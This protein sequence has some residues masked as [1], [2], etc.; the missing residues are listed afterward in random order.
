MGD[1]RTTDEVIRDIVEMG[2][3]PSFCTACYRL[4]R[5]GAD[6]MDMAKPGEI[7][8]HCTPNALS[9]FAE[10]LNDYASPETRAV[11]RA[12]I[13]KMMSEMEEGQVQ[14][15]APMIREV[16]L[17]QEGCVCV[18][19]L[20]TPASCRHYPSRTFSCGGETGGRRSSN[21]PGR[22]DG[23]L[24]ASGGTDPLSDAKAVRRATTR[25]SERS[26]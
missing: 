26:G 4:G 7:K 3:I 16:D 1:S 14:I 20:V 10:Y 24:L 22:F 18:A 15:A 25:W 12:M 8:Y 17:G 19:A 6:F 9:T 21:H 2:F 13:E 5:T 23:P 11:G